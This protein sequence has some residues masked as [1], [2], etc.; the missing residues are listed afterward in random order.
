V[1][2]EESDVVAE[3]RRL[4]DEVEALR[5]AL[6]HGQAM[7]L[8]SEQ[9]YE[10]I[11]RLSPSIITVT[12]FEDGTYYDVNEAFC[13]ATGYSRDGACTGSSL[14]LNLWVNPEDREKVK[15]LLE[16]EGACSN[17]EIAFRKGDGTIM[18]A[19]QSA[20]L[21]TIGADRFIIAIT[22]DITDRRRA[23]ATLARERERLSITLQSH[24]DGV[25][26]VDGAG[27]VERMNRAACVLVGVSE[28]GALGRPVREALRVRDPERQPVDDVVGALLSGGPSLSSSPHVL[29]CADGSER[30]V[31]LHASPIPTSAGVEGAVLVLRDVTVQLRM[32]EQ[33]RKTARLESLGVL[34]GGIAHD[35]NNVLMAIKSNVSFA[36]STDIPRNER[37]EA[38]ADVEDAVRRGRDLTQQLLTFSRGGAPIKHDAPMGDLLADVTAFVLRGTSVRL[39][40]DV[41]SDL[42]SVAVDRSQI[43]QV[44]ENLVVN[45]QQAM[46][47]GGVLRIT[48]CNFDVDERMGLQLTAGRYVRLSFE[49]DGPG[50]APADLPRVFDPFFSTKPGG[51]GLGLSIV[52]SVVRR[53]GGTVVARSTANSGACFDVYLPATVRT[54][55]APPV[56]S[57]PLRGTERILLMDDDPNVR[58]A[59][60][61][62]LSLMG[63][64][65]DVVV[66][67]R[68]AVT[69][70]ERALVGP[71][72]YALAILDLTVVGG[73]GGKEA[74]QRMRRIDPRAVIVVSSGYSDEG[75]LADPCAHGFDACLPKPY[76]ESELALVLR[77]VF[78]GR[79]TEPELPG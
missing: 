51:T 50:I 72:P 45:A 53:H 68:E 32:E 47:D 65:V 38:L 73:T 67:G 60:Q 29:T 8:S 31:L 11:F 20:E 15:R 61:R 37:Q 6:R 36:R 71:S 59:M 44:I 66:D 24:S 25:L 12:R 55:D 49:D 74:A 46:P 41:S 1:V 3:N 4:R 30:Q 14:S 79:C 10:S 21:V 40:L 2:A 9:I 43:S 70:Y 48:A 69:A 26:V 63:Y 27:C 7:P 75:I 19:L 77:R 57:E 17:V 78:S 39:S 13:R 54:S 76:D 52:H 5:S 58:R 42:M 16:T 22:T 35:F 64:R 62:A 34:A 18:Y 23:E 33:L 28:S 56:S